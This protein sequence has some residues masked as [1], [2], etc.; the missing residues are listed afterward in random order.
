MESIK[1]TKPIAHSVNTLKLLLKNFEGYINPQG[2]SKDEFAQHE[3]AQ[4]AVELIT[5]S[6]TQIN[7]A[8]RNPQNLFD[9]M[10]DDY[11]T[12]KNKEDRKNLMQSFE[13]LE[14]DTD[15]T[16]LMG[17]ATEMIFMLDTRLTE[18]RTT[19]NRLAR[20]LETGMAAN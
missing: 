9:K 20:K 10:K 5:G 2:Y 18:A 14:K 8:L 1:Y 15:F 16:K 11:N 3:E 19:A 17:E 6:I 12:M 13:A 4:K 7:S